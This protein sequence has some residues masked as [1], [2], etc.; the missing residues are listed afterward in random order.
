M[1]NGVK[2]GQ[3]SLLAVL[4][5]V[6]TSHRSSLAVLNG[7]EIGHRSLL[8]VLNGVET[9]CVVLMSVTPVV[10]IQNSICERQTLQQKTDS[11]HLFD[12]AHPQ[13]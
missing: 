11:E 3:R 4:N 2:T 6:E 9:S 8:A 12:M 7:V 5:G 13:W 10:I 1:L